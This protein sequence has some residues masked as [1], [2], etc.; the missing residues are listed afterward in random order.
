MAKFFLAHRHRR[1][2]S[3]RFKF[4]GGS[5][6][7]AQAQLGHSKMSTALEIYTLPLPEQQRATVEKLSVFPTHRQT[8]DLH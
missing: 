7:D 3:H 5:L 8:H 2:L 6:R 4:A 1:L